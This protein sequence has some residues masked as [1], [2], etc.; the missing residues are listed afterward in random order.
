[1]T[2]FDII[3]ESRYLSV[4]RLEAFLGRCSYKPS[5]GDKRF[6]VN[7]V[8]GKLEITLFTWNLCICHPEL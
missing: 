2:S 6:E 1:M 5:R 4:G 7:T 3:I 8:P